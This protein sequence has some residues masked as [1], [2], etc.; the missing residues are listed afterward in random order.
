[1][2]PRPPRPRGAPGGPARRRSA[3]APWASR[4]AA[5]LATA[6]STTPRLSSRRRSWARRARRPRRSRGPTPG[7]RA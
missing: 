5:P 4:A 7:R 6:I 3:T 1:M 2:P